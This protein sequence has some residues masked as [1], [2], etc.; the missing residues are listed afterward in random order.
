MITLL[1]IFFIKYELLSHGCQSPESALFKNFS[2]I[3]KELCA[4]DLTLK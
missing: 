3:L 4:C 2:G 1:V